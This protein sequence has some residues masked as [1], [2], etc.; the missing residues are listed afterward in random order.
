MQGAGRVFTHT[1]S[2]PIPQLLN[3]AQDIV[4]GFVV[5]V[6][7]LGI[8]AVEVRQAIRVDLGSK[9]TRGCPPSSNFL[10]ISLAL[11]FVEQSIAAAMKITSPS[12]LL[13]ECCRRSSDRSWLSSNNQSTVMHCH[14]QLMNAL[15]R[16]A[17][18]PA[19]RSAISGRPS[20]GSSSSDPKEAAA[21]SSGA[22]QR[23][24]VQ[25]AAPWLNAPHTRSF[26]TTA[27]HRWAP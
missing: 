8:P 9:R 11:L 24:P 20:C 1:A 12:C 2:P 7:S 25:L 10:G 14:P 19:M 15:V 27:P 23:L 22:C 5:K 3:F 16:G 17:L 21:S 6:D 26:L 4:A 13:R 18:G